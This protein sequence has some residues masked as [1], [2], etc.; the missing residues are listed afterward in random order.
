M[1]ID[2]DINDWGILL[3][4][5]RR[6]MKVAKGHKDDEYL[7]RLLYIEDKIIDTAILD[8]REKEIK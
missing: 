2:F 7:D 1:I 8:N 6:E 4:S 3:S 5:I